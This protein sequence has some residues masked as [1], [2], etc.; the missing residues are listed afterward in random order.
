[1]Q[2]L[3]ATLYPSSKTPDA[4][5]SCPPRTT[6]LLDPTLSGSSNLWQTFITSSASANPGTLLRFRAHTLGLDSPLPAPTGR[7]SSPPRTLPPSLCL[8]PLLQVSA[9]NP[10]LRAGASQPGVLIMQP[11]T[12]NPLATGSLLV[13][14]LVPQGEGAS[15]SRSL[16]LESFSSSLF[17]TPQIKLVSQAYPFEFNICQ[18]S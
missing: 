3:L 12:F 9:S 1:M 10:C 5:S 2:G 15:L 4:P 16:K 14:F 8:P 6:T 7:L 11:L 13:P 18:R 17:S